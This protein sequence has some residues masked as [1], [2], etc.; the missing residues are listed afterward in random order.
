MFK[1]GDKVKATSD[2]GLLDGISK[3]RAKILRVVENGG[4]GSFAVVRWLG[5]GSA[6][7][8]DKFGDRFPL[9]ELRKV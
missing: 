5:S 8:R 7:L 2:W 3:H 1:R 9:T 4:Y 6:D